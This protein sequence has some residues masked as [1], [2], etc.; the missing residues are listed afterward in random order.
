M[1]NAFVDCFVVTHIVSDNRPGAKRLFGS[2]TRLSCLFTLTQILDQRSDLFR[3]VSL[4]ERKGAGK[5]T[6]CQS[7]LV[8][9]P[10]LTSSGQ[11]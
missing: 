4:R 10:A 9:E 2:E 1:W 5:N 8:G 7:G 6:D 3:G 11:Y